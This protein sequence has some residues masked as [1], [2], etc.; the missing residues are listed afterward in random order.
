VTPQ[1][2]FSIA[3]WTQKAKASFFVVSPRRILYVT[4]IKKKIE[5]CQGRSRWCSWDFDPKIS[6][7][8]R[9]NTLFGDFSTLKKGGG[10]FSYTTRSP[11][12]SPMKKKTRN[13]KKARVLSPKK[14]IRPP[15]RE[16]KSRVTYS[17]MS[18]FEEEEEEEEKMRTLYHVEETRRYESEEAVMEQWGYDWYEPQL[19]LVYLEERDKGERRKRGSDV[20]VREILAMDTPRKVVMVEKKEKDRVY[21]S[22]SSVW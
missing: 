10:D 8:S 14:E 11:P 13:A 12:P 19:A 21:E 3:S 9:K 16:K 7:K 18:L 22:F 4:I 1:F 17:H 6:A 5:T 2:F 20:L 15:P